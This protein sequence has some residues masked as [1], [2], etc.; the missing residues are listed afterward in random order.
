MRLQPHQ[1]IWHSGPHVHCS[2]S[3]GDA[4]SPGTL[5]TLSFLGVSGPMKLL[6][7][8]GDLLTLTDL[9]RIS[10][11]LLTRQFDKLWRDSALM[12]MPKSHCTICGE[13]VSLQYITVHL[14]LEHQLGPND[15]HPVVVQLCRIYSAEHSEDP[16][17]DHCQE[18]LRH[19]MCSHLI[20]YQ[21]CTYLDAP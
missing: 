11:C 4:G 6:S 8:I 17:C 5:A 2:A 1:G 16:Y 3:G 12:N 15:L 9:K 10:L 21:N 13:S 20:Q 19:W 14:R 18:L 7:H